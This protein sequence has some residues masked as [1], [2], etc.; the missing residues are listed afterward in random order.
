MTN[1]KPNYEARMRYLSAM[2]LDEHRHRA[3]AQH[4]ADQEADESRRE[5]D[6][7]KRAEEREKRAAREAEREKTGH[8]NQWFA[9]ERESKGAP[10]AYQLETSDGAILTVERQPNGR[11]KAAIDGDRIYVDETLSLGDVNFVK[12]RVEREHTKRLKAKAA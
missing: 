5:R 11:W 3:I 8:L 4:I 6:A 9:T 7:V 10:T 2:Q 12:E 1:G